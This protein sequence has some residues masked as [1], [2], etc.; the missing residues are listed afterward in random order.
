LHMQWHLQACHTWVLV[1][2]ALEHWG[3]QALVSAICTVRD[4]FLLCRPVQEW[5]QQ[6]AGFNFEY[7]QPKC[8]H[9]CIMFPAVSRV[10]AASQYRPT[11]TDRD[12]GRF[13]SFGPRCSAACKPAVAEKSVWPRNNSC[14]AI[15]VFVEASGQHTQGPGPDLPTFV[16]SCAS[17]D[18]ARK[19]TIL[20]NIIGCLYFSTFNADTG[21]LERG[22]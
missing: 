9:L 17:V 20:Q 22:S 10:F 15:T 21:S 19:V 16:L 5:I 11:A 4:S 14:Q 8:L 18:M 3:K 7:L 13:N 2:A 6:S 12:T 1:L